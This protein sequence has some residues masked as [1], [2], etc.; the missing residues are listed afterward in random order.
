[1]SSGLSYCGERVR[2][3]DPERFRDA[4]FAPPDQREG[5]FAL[6]AFN[7]ELAKI[8]PMVS[9]PMLGE[10]RLQWWRD[11]LDMAEA[12]EP[13]RHAVAEPLAA[14]T[15]EAGLPR[16]LMD[17]MIDARASDLEPGFPQDDPALMRYLSQTAGSLTALA[18]QA[19]VPTFSDAGREAAQQAGLGI[20][21][22]R[23][24]LALPVL[25]AQGRAPLAGSIDWSA[26][27]NGGRS[28]ALQERLGSLAETGLAAIR[29]ARDAR[30]DIPRDAIPA[31]L[32]VGL[33]ERVLR[34]IRGA[35]SFAELSPPSEF[36]RQFGR[37]W[38]GTI[39]RW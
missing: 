5:L 6:Y 17:A 2:Q 22:A 26:L 14:I 3:G 13:R 38:R 39:R 23:Y 12:G 37:L 7:L 18:A 33:A 4:L 15:R 11:S 20:G 27:R 31:L 28:E 29:A 30:R 8:A 21:A 32:E 9:E 36:R 35:D 25:A 34:D 16:A 24:I 1:M 19:L 10:I